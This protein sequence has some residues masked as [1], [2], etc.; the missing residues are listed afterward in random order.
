MSG[1]SDQ[2]LQQSSEGFKEES[3]AA[4]DSDPLL[5]DSEELLLH[6]SSA[7]TE[8]AS[9]SSPSA[10]APERPAEP[11]RPPAALLGTNVTSV[12]H[13]P[14]AAPKPKLWSLAE[15]ATSSDRCRGGAAGGGGEAP[16]SSVLAG[17]HPPSP[18]RSSP[19]CPLSSATVLTRPLYYTSPFYPAYTNYG[20]GAGGGGGGGGG[21]GFPGAVGSA[22]HFNGLKQTVLNRAEVLVRE[23]S[24][25]HRARGH[26]QLELCKDSPYELKKGMSHI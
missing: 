22:A 8:A 15:I 25:S 23:S 4:R 9:S 5:S 21:G 13:S 7:D 10:A 2:K 16:H 20:A 18:A 11:S 26:T 19:H 6:D 3:A 1:S 24:G 12:I 14:P 17:N